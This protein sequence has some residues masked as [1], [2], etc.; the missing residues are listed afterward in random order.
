MRLSVSA[1]LLQPALLSFFP[2][3]LIT[4]C[5]MFRLSKNNS[6][7]QN[8]WVLELILKSELHWMHITFLLSTLKGSNDT[9]QMY[10]IHV[11]YDITS[12]TITLFPICNDSSNVEWTVWIDDEIKLMGSTDQR[13]VAQSSF[14]V[15]VNTQ[16]W[17]SLNVNHILVF[18]VYFKSTDDDTHLLLLLLMLD[19]F[20]Q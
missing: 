14:F 19:K 18:T 12:Q 7:F 15:F 11:I 6:L 4:F 8:C 1:E 10:A 20:E 9:F 16:K 2:L 3:T 13:Y 5:Y 17:I